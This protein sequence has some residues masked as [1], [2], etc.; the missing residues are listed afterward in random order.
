MSIDITK[1]KKNEKNIKEPLR[2][3]NTHTIKGLAFPKR[4]VNISHSASCCVKV[5]SLL[6]R[7]FVMI[8][9]EFLLGFQPS[10]EVAKVDI[11]IMRRKV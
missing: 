4:G 9:M 10:C 7:A 6:S 2:N 1:S 8:K 5:M 11:I 3:L